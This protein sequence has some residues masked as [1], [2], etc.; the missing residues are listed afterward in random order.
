MIQNGKSTLHIEPLK[1]IWLWEEK[2]VSKYCFRKKKKTI[3]TALFDF[4][5]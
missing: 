5:S 3:L 1:G 2:I 4:L